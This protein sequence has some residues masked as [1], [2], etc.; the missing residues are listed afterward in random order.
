MQTFLPHLDPY[1]SA[2]VLDNKRL[3]KQ[4]VETIQISQVLLGISPDSKWCNHPAVKMWRGYEP[5]LIKVYL[6]NIL[7]QW[8]KRGFRNDKCREHYKVLEEKVACRKIVKPVWLNEEF[9]IRHKSNLIRKAPEH[10]KHYWHTIPDNLEY[11]WP[12]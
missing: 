11:I 12:A 5:Y 4:R 2:Q 3:G 1:N 6:K 10:Y 7:E 9:C 8:E